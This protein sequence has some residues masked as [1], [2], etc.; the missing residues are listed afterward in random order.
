MEL[1]KRVQMFRSEGQVPVG[2]ENFPLN[3]TWPNMAFSGQLH[4]WMVEARGRMIG[5]QLAESK[6]WMDVP[7]LR[8]WGNVSLDSLWYPKASNLHGK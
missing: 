8:F 7:S 2:S 6:R 3:Q 1:S 4:S 5:N